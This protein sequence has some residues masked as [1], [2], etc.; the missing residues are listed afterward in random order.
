M[1]RHCTRWWQQCGDGG[2]ATGAIEWQQPEVIIIVISSSR[3]RGLLGVTVTSSGPEL[4]SN[5]YS[6]IMNRCSLLCQRCKDISNQHSSER[7]DSSRDH[8]HWMQAAASLA[9]HYCATVLEASCIAAMHPV[10]SAG[11][12]IRHRVPIVP[13]QLKTQC[14]HP[15]SV[16]TSSLAACLLGAA[17]HH[18]HRHE[19]SIIICQNSI[20]GGGSKGENPEQLLPARLAI[21]INSNSRSGM[22]QV[23]VRPWYSKAPGLCLEL[24]QR[25]CPAYSAVMQIL[26]SS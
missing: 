14:S 18:C 25:W 23:K 10:T 21:A 13:M 19:T 3:L 7:H 6:N 26:T 12:I 5:A 8:I 22:I 1:A 9:E 24:K 4:Y 16:D 15:T 2:G 20:M 11:R 17:V